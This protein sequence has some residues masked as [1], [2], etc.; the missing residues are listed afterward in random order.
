MIAED[1]VL[2]RE[3]LTRLLEEE[4]HEVAA[5][6]GDGQT[7]LKAVE[8]YEPDVAVVDVRM[9]PDHVNEGL[10][11]ALEIRRRMPGV[12]VLVLSQYVEE[13]YATE[14]LA[15]DSGWGSPRAKSGGVGYVLKD[16]VAA[17]GEFMDA[18]ERVAAGGTAL[19]PEVV[20]QLLARTRHCDPLASLGERE[21]EVLRAMAEGHANSRIA[22]TLYV[23]ESAVE[24]HVN[25]I[26]RK[27]DLPQTQ[28]Y[29]RRVMA[30]VRYLNSDP[31][32][33]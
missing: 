22:Q 8:E 19:D 24:K 21:L 14:L 20:R 1:S 23:S 2:L 18:L 6:V 12:A 17:V 9:P 29:S 33:K 30:V 5:A 13:R 10:V 28:G 3:G 32:G 7:L 26:F 15:D 25:N 31:D 4:G 16:R 11:A 27:L